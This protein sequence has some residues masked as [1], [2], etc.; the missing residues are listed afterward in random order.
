M[1]ILAICTTKVRKES[2]KKIF[3]KEKKNKVSKDL[4]QGDSEII[5][6]TITMNTYRI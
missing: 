5:P 2:K 4:L 3:K 1:F 6:K